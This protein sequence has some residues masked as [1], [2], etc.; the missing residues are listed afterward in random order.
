MLN[1][2]FVLVQSEKLKRGSSRRRTVLILCN[3]EDCYMNANKELKSIK[4]QENKDA[5]PGSK[6][7]RC[8]ELVKLS[9]IPKYLDIF[10]QFTHLRQM[11]LKYS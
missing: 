11:Y 4:E 5:A 8:L 6:H 1:H 7:C 10:D 9:S 2:S 3:G